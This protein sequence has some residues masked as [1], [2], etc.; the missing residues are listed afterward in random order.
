MADSADGDVNT[1]RE[2]VLAAEL[3]RARAAAADEHLAVELR[4]ALA[5]VGAAKSLTAPEE[6]EELLGM[7]VE[8]AMQVLR[9]S[10][11]TLYE[12]DEVNQQLIFAVTRGEHAAPLVGERMPIGHGFAG[13]AAVTGQ[14]IGTTNPEADP[15]WAKDFGHKVGY[16]PQSML[17]MPLIRDE[18]V[19]GVLQLMDK[20]GGEPF[21]AGDMALL[22]LF[23]QQASLAIAQS[24]RLHNLSALVRAVLTE[25]GTPDE[26]TQ[27]AEAFVSHSEESVEFQDTMRLA[28][29]LGEVARH[30]DSGRQ[31]ALDVA[32]ALQRYLRRQP[33]LSF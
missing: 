20:D 30:G 23:A 6:H 24:H 18:R 5:Q 2:A 17:T 28:E 33:Q 31:L 3:A 21:S 7:I 14:A 4:S 29:M 9:A 25:A 12:L 26:L 1:P 10:A 15:R 13:L 19:I 22:G 16:T 11:A 8:A 32:A 27:R